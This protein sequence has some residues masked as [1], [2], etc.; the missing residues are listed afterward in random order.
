[1]GA[2]EQLL[3]TDEMMRKINSEKHHELLEILKQVEHARGQI[4]IVSTLHDAG[5][6]VKGF[7]GMIAILRFR[8]DY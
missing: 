7:G 4:N 8:M 1:I 5:R 6:M 3:I 2:I